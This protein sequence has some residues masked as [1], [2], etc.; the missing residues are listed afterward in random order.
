MMKRNPKVIAGIAGI[1]ILLGGLIYMMTL[2]VPAWQ[3]VQLEKRLTPTPLPPAPD[4]VR[5]DPYPVLAENA[6]VYDVEVEELQRRLS[7]LGYL[8]GTVDGYFGSVTRN[9]VAEFQRANDLPANGVVDRTTREAIY[10]DNAKRRQ[11]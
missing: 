10:S 4:S 2:I 9:A 5:A 11:P 7:E 6:N 8:S 3:E 1:I